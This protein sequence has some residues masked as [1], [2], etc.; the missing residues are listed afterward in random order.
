MKN[1]GGAPE[2]KYPIHIPCP[3]KV[4]EKEGEGAELK[5]EISDFMKRQ[6]EEQKLAKKKEKIQVCIKPDS[7]IGKE[8]QYQTALLHE[9]LDEIREQRREKAV[10]QNTKFPFRH[11]VSPVASWNDIMASRHTNSGSGRQDLLWWNIF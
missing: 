9:I 10:S 5:K 3:S 11:L 8:I 7:Y 1:G 4:S 6:L 2:P